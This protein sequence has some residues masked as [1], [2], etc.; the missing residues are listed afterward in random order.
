MDTL[1]D[2][3]LV[4]AGVPGTVYLENVEASNG[5]NKNCENMYKP[6]FQTLKSCTPG[7]M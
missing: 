7:S 4:D 2:L 3:I 6:F 5:L 1:A